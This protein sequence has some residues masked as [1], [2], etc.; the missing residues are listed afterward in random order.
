MKG[1]FKPRDSRRERTTGNVGRPPSS[2]PPSLPSSVRVFVF[3]TEINCC[4]FINLLMLGNCFFPST[5]FSQ[6][7]IRKNIPPIILP[8]T[9]A[10]IVLTFSARSPSPSWTQCCVQLSSHI[11]SDRRQNAQSTKFHHPAMG[12]R[13]CRRGRVHCISGRVCS[14]ILRRHAEYFST[15][16]R[17]GAYTA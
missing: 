15:S 9:I 14:L 3:W 13:P 11:V 2:L 12:V 7:D 16:A 1:T 5:R 8:F 17:Y 6:I 10:L 4:L